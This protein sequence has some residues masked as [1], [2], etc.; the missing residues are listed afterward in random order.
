MRVEAGRPA[1]MTAADWTRWEAWRRADAALSH[2]HLS[3]AWMQATLSGRADARMLAVHDGA[4]V[5]GYLPVVGFET[6]RLRLPGFRTGARQAL[7]AAPGADVRLKHVAAALGSQPVRFLSA[8][9]G[10][11]A[12]RPFARG[13]F[14]SW[15][16]DCADGATAYEARLL[17]ACPQAVE[18]AAQALQSAEK[19]HGRVKL[20]AWRAEPMEA[21][22]RGG[23]LWA[24]LQHPSAR[25]LAP[26]ILTLRAGAQ[27]LARAASIQS[28]GV[29][30]VWL[31]RGAAE[32]LHLAALARAI[33]A[34]AGAD[35]VTEV[36]FGPRLPRACRP[37]ATGR[38]PLVWGAI[39]D[40]VEPSV[41]RAA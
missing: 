38:R 18:T 28:A 14:G 20:Q 36:D 26:T 10:Q 34:Q 6:G 11:N 13:A 8:S 9:A 40:R 19:I 30:H 29:M 21:A 5:C 17:A 1:A 41:A 7:I 23:G 16:A 4:D 39:S 35:R 3:P 31:Q 2:P 25:T 33:V 37:F 27:V 12:F 22:R 24:Y 32:A 15:V